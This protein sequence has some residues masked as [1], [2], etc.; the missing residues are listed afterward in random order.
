M[1][2]NILSLIEEKCEEGKFPTA[3]REEIEHHSTSFRKLTLY[4]QDFL[5]INEVFV[6]PKINYD[7]IFVSKLKMK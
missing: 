4:L 1:V 2:H 7:T 6:P 5:R 3:F